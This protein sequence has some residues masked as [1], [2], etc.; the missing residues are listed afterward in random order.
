MQIRYIPAKAGIQLILKAYPI[1]WIDFVEGFAVSVLHP[2]MF[3]S[4]ANLIQLHSCEIRNPGHIPAQA[5]IQFILKSYPI[6]WIDFVE[7]LA[8]PGLRQECYSVQ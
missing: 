3:I 1:S 8:V 2:G 5:G 6:F 4:S 7:G